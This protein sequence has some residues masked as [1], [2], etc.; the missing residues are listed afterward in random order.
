MVCG[1][2]IL[3]T[4]VCKRTHNWE[5]AP[6]RW[7]SF[8]SHGDVSFMQITIW[9]AAFLDNSCSLFG[10]TWGCRNKNNYR[11]R[12]FTIPWHLGALGIN[13][14]KNSH[15]K[16]WTNCFGRS[17]VNGGLGPRQGGSVQGRQG[18]QGRPRCASG[19]ELFG[20]GAQ[21]EE[22]ALLLGHMSDEKYEHLA[23]YLAK[24]VICLVVSV[25]SCFP[26]TSW[27]WW[28]KLT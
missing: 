8:E 13:G 14:A 11:I 7:C 27:D 12:T 25:F 2:Y 24:L 28:S 17:R 21:W 26:P 16:N 5:A 3:V 6:C 22:G 18:R 20:T 19:A 15:M 4:G 23:N 9:V 1:W 10:K